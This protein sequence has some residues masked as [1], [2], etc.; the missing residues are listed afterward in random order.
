MDIARYSSHTLCELC[1]H[2]TDMC[3]RPNDS[4]VKQI[5]ICPPSQFIK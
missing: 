3:V 2:V 1:E 4:S 5:I